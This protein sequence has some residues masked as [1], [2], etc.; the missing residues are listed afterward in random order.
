MLPLPI[1][2]HFWSAKKRCNLKQSQV[3]PQQQP[4]LAYQPSSASFCG[5]QEC[6]RSAAVEHCS[7]TKAFSMRV[8]NTPAS[9]S[10]LLCECRKI[11]NVN[12]SSVW[13][14]SHSRAALKPRCSTEA[15]LGVDGWGFPGEP[16][17]LFPAANSPLSPCDIVWD[18]GS[19]L[20]RC[21]G[22]TTETFVWLN[23]TRHTV[24]QQHEITITKCVSMP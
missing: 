17:A 6:E 10:T 14:S 13:S 21:T 9:D 19:F 4:L 7:A 24:C 15:V 16:T 5:W 23:R 2:K 20:Y 22:G 1:L 12:K 8:R 11:S 18:L 3:E